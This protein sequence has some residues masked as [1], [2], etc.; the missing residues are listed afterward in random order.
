MPPF[1]IDWLGENAVIIGTSYIDRDDIITASNYAANKWLQS[2]HLNAFEFRGFFVT[3][4]AA[5][6]AHKLEIKE[7][8]LSQQPSKYDA[9]I[10][11][12]ME[13][14]DEV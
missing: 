12:L 3:E 7:I 9:M 14:S 4:M 1:Q 2:F 11:K 8:P 10:A 5:T 6:S 13:D